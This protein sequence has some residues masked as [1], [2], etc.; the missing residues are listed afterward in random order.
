[1]KNTVENWEWSHGLYEF[2]NENKTNYLYINKGIGS[3]YGLRINCEP[4]ITVFTLIKE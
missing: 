1:M 2:N 4:E 3:H